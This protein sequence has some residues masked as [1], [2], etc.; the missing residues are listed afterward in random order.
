VEAS[1][2]REALETIK[3]NAPNLVLCDW[4]MPEMTGIELLRELRATNNPIPF[5]FVTSEASQEMKD[6]AMAAGA[7]FLITKPFTPKTFEESIGTV[8]A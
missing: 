5:G 6:T 2:G 8:A 1:N 7:Q 3:A 4:N